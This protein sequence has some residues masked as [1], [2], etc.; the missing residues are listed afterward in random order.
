MSLSRRALDRSIFAARILGVLI[1]VEFFL[2]VS[3][4]P[5]LCQR[6][7][8]AMDDGIDVVRLSSQSTVTW[9]QVDSTVRRVSRILRWWPFGNTCLRRCLVAG[10]LLREAHPRLVLGVQRSPDQEIRAHSWLCLGGRSIDPM[11]EH[12]KPFSLA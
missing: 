9:W 8:I 11:S 1:Q 12:F 5:A 6:L 3:S 10:A 2:R 4:L 7:G